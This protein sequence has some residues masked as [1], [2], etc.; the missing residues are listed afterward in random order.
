[1]PFLTIG[2]IYMVI[3]L[4]NKDKWKESQPVTAKQKK[5]TVGLI[6]AGIVVFLLVLAIY[7]LRV[8]E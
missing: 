1:L 5:I 7:L 8:L 6:A 2:L 3:G 4:A